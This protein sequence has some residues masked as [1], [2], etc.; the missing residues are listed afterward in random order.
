VDRAVPLV[1][2]AHPVRLLC[3]FPASPPCHSRRCEALLPLRTAPLPSQTTTTHPLPLLLNHPTTAPVQE[4]GAP[5]PP[6]DVAGSRD[7]RTVQSP[8]P[9][10][11]GYVSGPSN[12]QNGALGEQGPFPHPFPAKH[13]LLLA[14]FRPSS[15]L[16]AVWTTLR[17][18]RSFQGLERKIQGPVRK[19][20]VFRSRVSRLN[21]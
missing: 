21:L 4:S 8:P 11:A 7:G 9:A 12:P 3:S 14:G 17:G 1:S 6:L 19:K 13:G 16:S 15:S 10:P 2:V 5:A 20:S 18:L